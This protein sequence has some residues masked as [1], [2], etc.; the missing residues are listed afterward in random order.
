MNDG[1]TNTVNVVAMPNLPDGIEALWL[2]A[3]A[4]SAALVTEGE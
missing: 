4:V 2:V 3:F 1:G